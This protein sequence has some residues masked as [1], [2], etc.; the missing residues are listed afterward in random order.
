M[1]KKMDFI[2]LIDILVLVA[3]GLLM[4]FSASNVVANYKYPT[5]KISP[6]MDGWLNSSED[7]LNSG[8]ISMLDGPVFRENKNV[9]K[10][11]FGCDN[12]NIY[13]R[14]HVNKNTIENNFLERINQ[15]YI[16]MRNA[17][18]VKNRAYIRLICKTDNANPIL[19]EKFEHEL[20]L[21][22]VKDTLYPLRL[23]SCI[24]Q[25]IWTLTNSEDIKFVYNDVI[26]ITIPFGSLGIKS[27]E[28]VEFFLANTDSGVKNTHI[29]QEILLSLTRF[30][31][32][33]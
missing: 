17:T 29:S 27:G 15:F 10:I 4:V 2:L 13:F 21:T 31:D 19:C 20:T 11:Q 30:T 3:F 14:L 16:Y 1:R 32:N 23:A 9:D 26:D 12:N 22:L 5:E 8:N 28:T 33:K 24:H 18:A 25:N 7:W 6:K